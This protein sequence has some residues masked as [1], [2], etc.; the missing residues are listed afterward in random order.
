VPLSVVRRRALRAWDA[1]EA[2]AGPWRRW[3]VCLPL[4][5]PGLDELPNPERLGRRRH[6]DR[7]TTKLLASLSSQLSPAVEPGAELAVE[8]T[9][10]ILDLQPELG[11]RLA[12]A[13]NR[14]GLARPLLL[15]GRWPYAEAVL[16]AWPVVDTA[17]AESRGLRADVSAQHVVAVLDGQR[18][19]ACP[20]RPADDPRADNR[21]QL[22]PQDLPDTEA[23]L[24]RGIRQVI[25]YP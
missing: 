10:L 23:R 21:Y 8:P 22:A 24:A 12:A 6:A 16:P 5:G 25:T 15:L 11:L 7:R 2:A 19:L 4:L 18:T 9:L 1:W 20:D 17:M 13:M 14:Q 3:S